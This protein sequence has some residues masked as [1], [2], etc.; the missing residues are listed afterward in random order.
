[1]RTWSDYRARDFNTRSAFFRPLQIG[2]VPLGWQSY[3]SRGI[4]LPS[5]VRRNEPI[6]NSFPSGSVIVTPPP[7]RDPLAWLPPSSTIRRT[8]SS[9]S[10]TMKHRWHRFLTTFGSGIFCSMNAVVESRDP[11][12][13]HAPSPRRGPGFSPSIAPQ[14]YASRSMSCTSRTTEAVSKTTAWPDTGGWTVR[15]LSIR[16]SVHFT[17]TE[18]AQGFQTEMPRCSPW[19]RRRICGMSPQ[20][21]SPYVG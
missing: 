20:S 10:G 8:A 17:P 19:R 14:K 12:V 13:I 18:H 4:R 21:R 15:A 16:V 3:Q 9:T 5:L 2:K 11:T 7:E 6:Q 1:M